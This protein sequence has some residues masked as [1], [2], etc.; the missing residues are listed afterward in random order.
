MTKRTSSFARVRPPMR[1]HIFLKRDSMNGFFSSP[2][3]E[4]T[5]HGSCMNLAA[6]CKFA[7]PKEQAVRHG[8]RFETFSAR[9]VF[10]TGWNGVHPF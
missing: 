2:D 7:L 8:R 9:I 1:K 6:P 4:F 10:I 5:I 3:R